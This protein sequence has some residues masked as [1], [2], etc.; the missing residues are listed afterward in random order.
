MRYGVRGAESRVI[1]SPARRRQVSLYIK[2][3]RG[4]GISLMRMAKERYE[5]I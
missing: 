2:R 5:F 4:I 3:G 1:N